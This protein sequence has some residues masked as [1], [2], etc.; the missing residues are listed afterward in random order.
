[1]TELIHIRIGKLEESCCERGC[2]FVPQEVSERY[3]LA[4]AKK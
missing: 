1:M 4:Q 3:I 2:E